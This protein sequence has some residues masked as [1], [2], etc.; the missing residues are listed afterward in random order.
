MPD[1]GP[2][3]RAGPTFFATP[4][5]FR[6][7]LALY[8]ETEP[9]L[10]V[11]F[12]KVGSG[13]PSI[14]WPESVDE[15][16]CAGWIDGVR[17]RLDDLSYT[18]RFTPRRPRSKWSRINLDRGAA[19][20]AEGRVTSAGLAAWERRSER[21]PGRYSHERDDA[22]TLSPAHTARFRRNRK[23]WI[24]FGKTA[25]GYRRMMVRWIGSARQESTRERRLE[26]LIEACAA[27]RRLLP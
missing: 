5:E 19:L 24:F 6:R 25:P 16:L 2:G 23:A 13:K 11:G 21:D 8:G 20:I 7:W 27:S 22:V 4:E 12:Y 14:T 3:R 26:K 15:A 17:R 9:E 1:R 10:T 18:I